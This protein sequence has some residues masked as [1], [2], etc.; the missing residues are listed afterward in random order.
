[1]SSALRF[2]IAAA[3]ALGLTAACSKRPIRPA[4]SDLMP[5]D[6]MP[7]DAM[8]P[9]ATPPDAMPPEETCA[10]AAPAQPPPFPTEFRFRNDSAAPLF[11]GKNANCVDID[12]GISSCASGFR[13]RLGPRSHCGCW[14]EPFGCSTCGACPPR[15]GLVVP[16]D[17]SVVAP[18]NGI[19]LTDSEQQLPD[20]GALVS[21]ARSRL[22][23]A[24]RY[25]VAIRV[26]DDQTAAAAAIGGRT[27]T[28]DFELPSAGNVVEVPLGARALDRCDPA[29][30]AAA[31]ICT[32]AEPRDVP[33]SL[34][35]PLGFAFEGGLGFSYDSSALA[36]PATFARR[37]VFTSAPMPDLNCSTAIP[38]CAR[39]SR[40][41]TTADLARVLTDPAVVSAYAGGVTPVYGYD[42]RANDGAV[43]VLR[44]PDGTS[45][46]IGGD[47]DG[48]A[49]PLTPALKAVPPVF[50]L[51]EQQMF[52]TPAC[53][54]FGPAYRY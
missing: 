19:E 18:W 38:R 24:G 42:H 32:G 54:A 15:E 26:F 27:V 8:P 25:R 28:R 50:S 11:I 51:L 14:C 7:P 4:P 10:V 5:P 6:A 1:M 33:C 44:R 39:D 53:A 35:E 3:A 21:C 30:D 45:L 16:A 37:R 23:P 22:L 9:D 34:A 36:P 29:P 31:P 43:L 20:G 13:D 48:C 12:F 17:G 2:V 47:C 46:A 52:A 40:V 41:V 49:R